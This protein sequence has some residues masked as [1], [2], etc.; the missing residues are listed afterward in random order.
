M[1][2][3]AFDFVFSLVINIYQGFIIAYYLIKVLECKEQYNRFLVY[4]IG[5]VAFTLLLKLQRLIVV[6]EG[7][8]IFALF[9]LVAVF[10]FVFLE[11]KLLKKLMHAGLIVTIMVFVSI[12]D[13]SYLE[14][15]YDVS[16][17]KY[18]CMVLVQLALYVLVK[19]V[20]K[21]TRNS[22]LGDNTQ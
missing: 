17:M 1:G 3:E 14:L 7:L 5:T 10:S 19:M 18:I 8:G 6:F 12:F 20:V 16:Y 22:E 15:V 13:S 11:G 21:H 9:L 2:I 4:G